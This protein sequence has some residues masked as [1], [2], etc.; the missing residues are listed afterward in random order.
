MKL[1]WLLA[2]LPLTTFAS[3]KVVDCFSCPDF[4]GRASSI[5]MASGESNAFI[6]I[7]DLSTGVIKRYY[8]Q[9]IVEPGYNFYSVT[10]TSV[11]ASVA[12]NFQ[13]L[14]NTR[15]QIKNSIAQKGDFSIPANVAESGYDVIGNTA[16]QNLVVQMYQQEMDLRTQIAN[17]IALGAQ[18]FTNVFTTNVNLTATFTFPDGS[19]AE[20]IISGVDG[21]GNIQLYFKKAVD[22]NGNEIPQ[23]VADYWGKTYQLNAADVDRFVHNAIVLHN[24]TVSVGGAGTAKQITCSKLKDS[25]VCSAQN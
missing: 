18:L 25:T 21:D 4:Q 2:L 22:S 1:A 10:E 23:S 17:Y 24:V 16:T 15:N 6:N 9:K 19:F 8:V 12:S 20:F 7:G 11:G 14:Y 3:E 5:V 13:T